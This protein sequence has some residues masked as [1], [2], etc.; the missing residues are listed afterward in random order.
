MKSHRMINSIFKK[1]EPFLALFNVLEKK[2]ILFN[3]IP[4]LINGTLVIFK[5]VKI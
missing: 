4:F 3:Q 1:G 5:G 2:L